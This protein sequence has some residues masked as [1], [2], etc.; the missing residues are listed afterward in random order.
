MNT[1]YELYCKYEDYLVGY[2]EEFITIHEYF[3][4]IDGRIAKDNLTVEKNTAV[5]LDSDKTRLRWKQ[6][7]DKEDINKYLITWLGWA[8]CIL[9]PLELEEIKALL[10]L[11]VGMDDDVHMKHLLRLNKNIKEDKTLQLFLRLN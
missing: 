8:L 10:E 6:K 5:C 9:A 4:K 11:R 3:L 7:T 1:L 2:H